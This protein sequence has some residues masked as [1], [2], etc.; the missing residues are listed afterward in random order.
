MDRGAWW[1]TVHGVVELDMINHTSNSS[2]IILLVIFPFMSIN[3][4]FMYLI[5]PVS[6][7]YVLINKKF[8]SYTDLFTMI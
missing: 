1:A 7:T 2:I 8:S 5:V 6:V 3:I 4:C